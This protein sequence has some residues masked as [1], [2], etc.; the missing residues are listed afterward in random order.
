M[1]HQSLADC[2]FRVRDHLQCRWAESIAALV[3]RFTLAAIFWRSGNTKLPFGSGSTVSLFQEEY[4]KKVGDLFLGGVVP[5]WMAIGGAYLSTAF[6]L[7]CAFL[8]FFG[9]FSR[10]ASLP[11]IGIALFIQFFVYPDH[12][13]EH[14]AWFSML[15]FILV[16]GPGIISL[17]HLLFGRMVRNHAGHGQVM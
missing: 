4:L 6:E 9:L 3:T 7:G 1:K 13:N 14:F 5:D 16:R 8:L 2:L 10:L 15:L 12:W 17:D 11:L